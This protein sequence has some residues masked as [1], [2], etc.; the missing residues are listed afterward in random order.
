MTQWVDTFNGIRIPASG[1]CVSFEHL[2]SE[3]IRIKRSRGIAVFAEEIEKRELRERL[4]QA[5]RGPS[6]CGAC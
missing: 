4:K 1:F 5:N 3:V 6:E 2:L